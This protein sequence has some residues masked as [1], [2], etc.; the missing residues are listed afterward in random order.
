[1]GP[2]HKPGLVHPGN[3]G[4]KTRGSSPPPGFQPS[5]SQSPPGY[6]PPSPPGFQ[7]KSLVDTIRVD[8][9]KRTIEMTQSSELSMQQFVAAR[10]AIIDSR[11]KEF[12]A[13]NLKS[14]AQLP[15][16]DDWKRLEMMYNAHRLLELE[17]ARNP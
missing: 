5:L 3:M 7:P 13:G 12:T 16:F 15:T 9:Q 11:M 8:P 1:M 6:Q 4:P 10:A 2:Y 17:R 14:P